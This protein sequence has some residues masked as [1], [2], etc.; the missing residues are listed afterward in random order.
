MLKTFHLSKFLIHILFICVPIINGSEELQRKICPRICICDTFNGLR[1]ADCS[2]QKLINTHT[3]IPAEMV[4][5][6]DLSRNEISEIIDS[7]MLV[8]YNYNNFYFVQ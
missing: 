2:Q 1:R 6:L 4:D 8:K 7:S 3:D 5:I